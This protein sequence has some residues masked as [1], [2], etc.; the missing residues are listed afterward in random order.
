M[1]PA[2]AFASGIAALAEEEALSSWRAAGVFWLHDF[3]P[4]LEKHDD[5]YARLFARVPKWS[6]TPLYIQ[7]SPIWPM[8]MDIFDH[9]Q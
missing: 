2:D 5:K 8:V 3:D 1:P 6:P 7:R 9:I 4:S